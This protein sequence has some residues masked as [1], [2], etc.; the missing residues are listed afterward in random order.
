MEDNRVK[1]IANFNVSVE[2][3][4]DS[5]SCFSETK[6]MWSNEVGKVTEEIIDEWEASFIKYL[7]KEHY[8]IRNCN[9]ICTSFFKLDNE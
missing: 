5:C 8:N 2:Y 1:V 4:D 9:V 3:K 6:R 7:L